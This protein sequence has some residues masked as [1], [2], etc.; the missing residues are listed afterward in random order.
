MKVRNA[1]TPEPFTVAPDADIE[2]VVNE[3]ARHNTEPPS[4]GIRAIR[5]LVFSLSVDAMNL[6]AAVL[7]KTGHP[8]ELPKHVADVGYSVEP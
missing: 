4:F 6:L 8:A 3:M 1:M 5:W 7:H 2:E